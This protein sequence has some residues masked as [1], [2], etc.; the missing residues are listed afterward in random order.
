VLD[1]TE[2]DCLR[3]ALRGAMDLSIH[4]RMDLAIHSQAPGGAKRIGG[5]LA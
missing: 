4:A 1:L 2:A 3:V 5:W